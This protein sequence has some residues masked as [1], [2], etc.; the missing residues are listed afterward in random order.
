MGVVINTVVVERG[1]RTE[2]MKAYKAGEDP[3]DV[4]DMIMTT[5][6]TG[7]SEKYGWLGQVPE[8]VEWK[9]KRIIKGLN[10]FDYTI[11][12]KNYEGTLGVDR[13]ELEDDQYGQIKIRINELAKKARAFPRKKFFDLILAGETDLCY[14]GN[15]FFSASHQE[16]LSGVQSNLLTHTYAG[17]LPT[18]AELKA[19]FDEAVSALMSY[20]DDQGNLMNDSVKLSLKVTCSL[21]MR[22]L[23]RELLKAQ[24]IDATTN[25]NVEEAELLVTARLSGA[26]F[27]VSILGEPIKPIV[28][29]K[30]RD[31]TFA[32]QT[33]DSNN[34]FMQREFAY[35]VDARYGWG[36]GLWQRMV[37]MSKA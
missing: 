9:D 34:G 6:S 12:N 4:M 26:P 36:Y 28:W 13:N 18:L 3:K 15:A 33:E 23:F 11:P 22:T 16:G 5:N 30:R 25:V 21:A 7:P 2:F 20:K 24:V 37:K 27:Y 14:D 17:T 8:M 19:A 35:G 10:D 1:L 31:I 32:S 29:Q